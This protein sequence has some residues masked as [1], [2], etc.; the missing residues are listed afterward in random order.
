M[1]STINFPHMQS[2]FNWIRNNQVTLLYGH[3]ALSIVSMAVG[4][5]IK[6]TPVA[7]SFLFNF[8]LINLSLDFVVYSVLSMRSYC[9]SRVDEADDA[10]VNFV[11][12]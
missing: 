1:L 8:G 5:V 4:N 10:F 12:F 7:S 11:P 3:M 6:S 9:N 2:S